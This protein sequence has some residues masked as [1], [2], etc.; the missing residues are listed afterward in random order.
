MNYNYFVYILTN[1]Y[2]TV[3]Y[4][5]VTNNLCRRVIEHKIKQ[6]R[7]FTNEYNVN[8]LVHYELFFNIE[9][10]IARE[11]RLKRWNRQWKINLIEKTN[12]CWNDLAELIGAT[13]EAIE[14]AKKHI[15]KGDPRSS[16]G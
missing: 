16:R 14:N 2:H 4:T 8:K 6:N 9:D 13:H 15:K 5:G 12:A 3:F 7:G 11:K 1:K 10:A